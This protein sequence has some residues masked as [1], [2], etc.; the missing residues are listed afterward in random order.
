MQSMKPRYLVQK[1]NPRCQGCHT[2]NRVTSR[3]QK[4]LSTIV[5]HKMTM[6]ILHKYYFTEKLLNLYTNN[7]HLILRDEGRREFQFPD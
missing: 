7:T 5:L 4:F 3:K 1:L 2:S 6:L